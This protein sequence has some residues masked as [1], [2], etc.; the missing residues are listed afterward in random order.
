MKYLKELSQKGVFDSLFLTNLTKSKNLTKKIL[1]NYLEKDLIRKVKYNLYAVVNLETNGLIS[2]KYEIGSSINDTSFVSHHS[3]FEFY[4]YYNQMYNQITVSSIKKFTNFEF[5]NN[6]YIFSQA[7][8]NLQVFNVKGVMVTSL[9]RTIVDEI[10]SIRSVD[11]IDEVLKCITLVPIVNEMQILEYL[12]YKGKKSLYNKVGLILSFFKE[13]LFLSDDF[14]Y[15]MS[16]LYSPVR[17]YFPSN[18]INN[19]KYY[20][21][22]NLYSVDIEKLLGSEDIDV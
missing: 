15:R 9:A 18:K 8:S 12:R 7:K 6:A 11:E 22:W 1:V 17:R 21:E 14:F 3:A 10:D 5:E 20:N 13:D 19:L 16:N 2:S 4:G